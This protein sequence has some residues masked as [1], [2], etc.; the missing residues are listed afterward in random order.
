[1]QKIERSSI[2]QACFLAIAE[3]MSL[4][5]EDIHGDMLLRD[6]LDI[7]SLDAMNI[8]MA[9]EDKFQVEADIETIM[10]LEKVSEIIDHIRDVCSKT[11]E[12]E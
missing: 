7:Q 3:E 9:L 12:A 4:N 1:M 10:E 8:I 11:P 5:P 6:D 2:E